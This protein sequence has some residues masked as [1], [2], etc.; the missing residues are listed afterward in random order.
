M[1]KVRDIYAFF[2][3]YKENNISFQMYKL[4]FKI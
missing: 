2:Y 4:T 3:E 1:R